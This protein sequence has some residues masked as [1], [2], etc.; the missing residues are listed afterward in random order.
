MTKVIPEH[1][2]LETDENSIPPPSKRVCLSS[3]KRARSHANQTYPK[4]K[5]FTQQMA[6]SHDI[7]AVVNGYGLSESLSHHS[8][9]HNHHSH[10]QHHHSHQRNSSPDES[11]NSDNASSGAAPS[12]CP[13]TSAPV[14]TL[15][16]LG[17]TCFLNSVLYTLRFAPS[18]LHNL[19]HLVSD[20][21]EIAG[22]HT[23]T[24][25]KAKSSSLGRSIGSKSWSKD[26]PLL[27]NTDAKIAAATERLHDLFE[28]LHNS[29]F[30]DQ[31]EP[32]QPEVFLQS[33]RDV[34]PM[35]EG[36]QQHDAHEL[37][38]CLIDN[39]RE[40]CRTLMKYHEMQQSME[41]KDKEAVVMNSLPAVTQ[42]TRASNNKTSFRLK[43][44]AS[45]HIKKTIN[46]FSRSK[47][48]NSNTN[49]KSL[50]SNSF[51]G[52]SVLTEKQ[53]LPEELNVS[54]PVMNGD[55][56]KSDQVDGN[57]E[58]DCAS[59]PASPDT[60]SSYNFIA[61]DFQGVSVQCTVCLECEQVTQRQETFCDICVPIIKHDAKDQEER[62]SQLYRDSIVM[63]E[64]L[65]ESNK[66]WCEQCCRYNEAKRYVE[67]E[68]LPRLLT[69]QLKRFS[70]C[71]SGVEKVN[72]YMP[73]PFTLDCFCKDCSRGPCSD[74]SKQRHYYQLYG[75]I[76]HLGATIASG[77]YVAYVRA[78]DTADC[79]AHVNCRHARKT[80]SLTSAPTPLSHPH[81]LTTEKQSGLMRFFKR[82]TH[83]TQSMLLNDTKLSPFTC[84]SLDCCGIRVRNDSTV[85]SVA[86]ES[87]WLECDDDTIRTLSEKDF[88][89]ILEMKS[90]KNLAST[91]YLLFYVRMN[92]D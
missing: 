64:F 81:P 34:N 72:E 70:S 76:M 71:N 18:F 53:N 54:L 15:S 37:L 20:L 77:H 28:S 9:H 61:D 45:T 68:T 12:V 52:K 22:R 6:N 55:V 16:N 17:N 30:K 41:L 66:Y 62:V 51:N 29:E 8:H 2:V 89:E 13:A 26:L 58:L 63:D 84:R 38:V 14:A 74:S 50:L 49:G 90:S 23:S 80:A 19:H 32:F 33:L 59:P 31:T 4:S 5:N 73:T 1:W 57:G 35:F 69:L 43:N 39:I 40:T 10:H 27:N 92:N 46:R 56:V 83:Q 79:H 87:L 11:S 78:L 85:N 60:N 25:I 47:N 42:H 7:G 48:R 91:P 82:S 44:S 88:R 75:V 21:A 3:S 36:N 65:V 67:Y 24:S 86:H